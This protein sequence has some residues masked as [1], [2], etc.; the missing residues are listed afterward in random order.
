MPVSSEI[1]FKNTLVRATQQGASDLHFVAGNKIKAKIDNKLV[2]FGEDVI[3]ES[4][5]ENIFLK[6]IPETYQK[7]FEKKGSCVFAAD[8]ADNLR[9][10][11]HVFKQESK[12]A[13][14]IRHVIDRIK[15]P[16]ELNLP[17]IIENVASAERGL[18]IVSGVTGSGKTTTISS[19]L[20]FINE[21]LA[22]N[23]V[24][25]ERPI[26]YKFVNKKS[27]V[28]QREIY[29]DTPSF[30]QG[31]E[32]LIDM[33]VSTV[34]VA[35]IESKKNVSNILELAEKS[36]VFLEMSSYSVEDT[37]NDFMS[38]FDGEEKSEKRRIL[39]SVLISVFNLVLA[40]RKGGSRLPVVELMFN[41]QAVSS[42]IYEDRLN[43]IADM[44]TTSGQDGMISKERSLVELVKKGY[45][46]LEEALR[47]TKNK[48]ELKQMILG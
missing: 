17:K 28:E 37:L 44:I 35:K 46:D 36:L 26:E 8:L 24:T 41:I 13:V 6:M 3:T 25:L 21:N 42:L 2:D 33:D 12:L 45:V 16:Q 34:F 5:I 29:V 7:I 22:R 23:I 10:R 20:E 48:E 1:E 40:A 31:T 30:T 19:L 27:I 39:S 14:S 11:L 38:V 43:R 9:F 15:T 47:H 18:V 32:D 4:F